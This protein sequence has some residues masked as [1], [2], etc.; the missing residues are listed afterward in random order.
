MYDRVAEANG[1][2]DVIYEI[3]SANYGRRAPWIVA[4]IK[5]HDWGSMCNSY[6]KNT[7]EEQYGF[8]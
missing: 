4:E 8:M 6:W 5:C 2:G 3:E 7:Q 1:L